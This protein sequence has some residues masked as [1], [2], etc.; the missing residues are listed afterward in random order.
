MNVLQN[1]IAGLK[2]LFHKPSTEREL[3]EELDG[4]LAAS[5]AHKQRIGMSP[6]DARRAARIEIGSRNAVKHQVWT[7]RWESIVDGIL[8]D[9]RLSLRSMSKTPGFTLVALLSL[10]LGI[11]ANTAIFTLINQVMLR[12]LPVQ[13]PEQLVT[14][15]R[16]V[17]GGING[18]MDIGFNDL[19]TWDFARQLEAAPGPFQGV[20][21][22]SSF[23]PR[24]SVRDLNT[25]GTNIPA[26][27]L[28]ASMVSD[29]YFTVLGATPI[30]GRTFAPSEVSTPGS[31]AVAILGYHFWQQ[32]LGSD[33]TIVGKSI[34]INSTPFQVI[35]VM[36]PG[37]LGIKPEVHP[38]DM[39]VPITMES[40][41][42]LQ[43]PFLQPRGILFLHLFARRAEARMTA[44]ALQQDQLWFDG[45]VHSYIR[46]GEGPVI[47]A[48]RQQEINR[49]TFK[50]LPG[51]HG[52]SYLGARYG[53]AL[54]VLLVVTALVLLI[55]CANLANFLLAR[56]A[57]RQREIA[58][59]LALGSSRAR[60]IRQSL[61]ETLLLS[62]FGGLLG[63]ALAFAA[64]RALI[65]FVTQGAKFTPLS[66]IPDAPVLFFTLGVSL[67]TGLLFGLGPAIATARSMKAGAAQSLSSNTRATTG[68][69]AARLFPRILVT[70][71]IM[72]S[73][74]LLIGAGLFIR[75][76]NNLQSQDYGFERTHM[77]LAQINPALG[78]YT[79]ER[80]PA[81]N[82]TIIERLE[83]MPGVRSASLSETPP[84]SG[85][86]WGGGIVIPGYTPAPKE[87]MTSVLNR[88]SGH[89]FETTG[90][91]IISGRPINPSDSATSPKV[92][93]I[94]ESIAKRY[95][96][97]NDAVGR[98]LKIEFDDMPGPYQIVGIAR[99]SRS[100][101]PRDPDPRPTTY[102][103]L[104][105]MVGTN[106]AASTVEVRT[107]ADP[108]KSIADMRQTLT[109]IDPNL[110]LTEIRT[111]SEQIGTMMSQEQLFSTLTTIFSA[112]ALLL[113]AIGLYGVIS[114][115]VVRR[116]NE[117]G[118][119]LAL[120]S[121]TTAVLWMILRESLVLLAVG[122]ILGLPL[123]I[124][125]TR[126]I[127]QQLF[128]L[129]AVDPTTFACAI[130]VVT[131]MTVLAAWL[132]ARRAASTNP[133]VALRCD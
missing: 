121:Q 117:I 125:L 78:G 132:P 44:A 108:E 60:I 109:Q 122:L 73:L 90:I 22:Y 13:N 91:Q 86:T 97:N 41:I 6:E 105:Q 107:T 49:A 19:V 98:S 65:A 42:L 43:P 56:A 46:A 66:P 10:A 48:D 33:A 15:G 57:T 79:P 93:V 31:S 126:L 92:A 63:L 53:D 30:L 8:Q 2:S 116:T 32:Q 67:V 50:L 25:T 71:Q 88:V 17:G 24:V 62:L 94:T 76:L 39:W 37:F 28:A 52:V 100:G 47:S 112:L 95:F 101:N 74:L 64:T 54:D 61:I 103:A 80:T 118:I 29:N 11:G 26:Q 16:S 128:G 14:M 59:R 129:T 55:A 120:G 35:G 133:M 89:F 21:A 45:Q 102:L 4:Y 70:A 115:S 96:P 23:A 87:D 75:S 27:Q 123:T 127:R 7:S 40:Q 113:A 68:S 9:M 5:A 51:A 131:A 69:R 1:L 81:L 38:P 77:L 12:N 110:P 124:A 36:G 114:Y 83:A 20:A 130:V 99:D 111:I 72:L 104:S 3:D 106:A 18:G 84:I 58:T 82:Q 119:R 34:S 85:G